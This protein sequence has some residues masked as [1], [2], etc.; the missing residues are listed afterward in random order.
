MSIFVL[1]PGGWSGAWT[2]RDVSAL[3]R[4]E[5]HEVLP[6]TLTGLGERSHLLSRAVD[7]ETHIRDVVNALAWNELRDVVLVGHS[8]AGMPITGAADR[9]ADRIRS[10]VYLDA[11]LPQDGQSLFDIMAE[12]RR[13]QVLAL[14]AAEGEGWRLPWIDAPAFRVDDEVEQARIGRLMTAHPLATFSQPVALTGAWQDIPRF[15]YI[16]AARY[17]PSPMHGFAA[18]CREDPRWMVREIDAHH[19]LPVLKPHEV[20]AALLDAA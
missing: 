6:L 13:R 12:D 16:L 5:G 3:L 20:V 15:T 19:M 11:F 1:V 9:A 2:W 14:A 8:Y 17:D 4:A 10:L 7:L 18:R